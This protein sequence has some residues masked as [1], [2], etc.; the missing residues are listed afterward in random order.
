M[1]GEQLKMS[2]ADKLKEN[3]VKNEET[4]IYQI[5]KE[6]NLKELERLMKETN[7]LNQ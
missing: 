7:E 1:K 5:E 2:L 4:P 6:Q 3:Q